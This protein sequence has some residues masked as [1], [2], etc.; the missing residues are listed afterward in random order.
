MEQ[1][2]LTTVISDGPL[3]GR[4]GGQGRRVASLACITECDRYDY[5]LVMEDL[6]V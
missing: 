2:T 5:G 6:I 4:A 3:C 1:L